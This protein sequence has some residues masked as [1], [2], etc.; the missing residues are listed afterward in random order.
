MLC[1][2]LACSLSGTQSSSPTSQTVC[3]SACSCAGYRPGLPKPPPPPVEDVDGGEPPRSPPPQRAPARLSAAAQAPPA[4][5]DG[6]RRAVESHAKVPAPTAIGLEHKEAAAPP[7]VAVTTIDVVVRSSGELSGKQTAGGAHQMEGLPTE[8]ALALPPA[9]APPKYTGATPGGLAAE[10]PPLIQ[11]QGVRFA[12]PSRPHDP[13]LLDFSL[14][15]EPGTTLALVGPS[16]SGKSTIVGLVLRLYDVDAGAVLVDGVDVRAWN[17]AALRAR[18]A[19]VQQDPVLFSESVA[20][21]ILYGR[22]ALREAV[23]GADGAVV[24]ASDGLSEARTASSRR[25]RLLPQKSRTAREEPSQ[26][27]ELRRPKASQRLYPWVRGGSE[28]VAATEAEAAQGWAWWMPRWRG[29]QPSEQRSSSGSAPDG[30]GRVGFFTA[31]LPLSSTQRADAP[32]PP[33]GALTLVGFGGQGGPTPAPVSPRVRVLA[34]ADVDPG[35]VAA[36]RAANAAGFIDTL[37][38]A[39]GTLVGTSV[40]SAQ[41]SGGQRQR[42]AIARAVFR[43]APVLL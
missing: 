39:Y 11:F 20:A 4:T 41:L 12:Y 7:S 40:S 26:T 21:N 27:R 8:T 37:P 16:G 5:L 42:I 6:G 17:V 23:V 14:V 36:A 2:G 29:R 9:V 24:G 3:R 43:D 18:M 38:E 15:I 30:K 25:W 22:A 1:Y 13:V 34:V 35:V 32:R 31:W 33:S 19:L 28:D 10:E